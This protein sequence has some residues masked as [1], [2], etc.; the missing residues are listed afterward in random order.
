MSEE[1]TADFYAW[2]KTFYGPMNGNRNRNITQRE[3]NAYHEGMRQM[4]ASADALASAL[5]MVSGRCTP[6]AQLVINAALAAY[7]GK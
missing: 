2:H 7:R 4:K 3:I 6:E 1:N 5:E